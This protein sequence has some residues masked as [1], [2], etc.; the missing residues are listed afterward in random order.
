MLRIFWH[1]TKFSC[2]PIELRPKTWEIVCQLT[3]LSLFWD[4][5][6]FS[7]ENSNYSVTSELYPSLVS[8]TTEFHNQHLSSSFL[9]ALSLKKM[10]GFL[11]FDCKSAANTNF[12]R[13]FL[14]FLHGHF[15]VEKTL[16]FSKMSA[17]FQFF[18][19]LFVVP[20]S[21]WYQ[22][23]VKVA[24]TCFQKC[25]NAAR[26]TRHAKFWREVLSQCG[27]PGPQPSSSK[28][29]WKP[30]FSSFERAINRLSDLK[31]C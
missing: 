1:F 23:W 29:I 11:F 13:N 18:Q 9:R 8:K 26:D 5:A 10:P 31:A 25:W 20:L 24:K 2:L 28:W 4:I 22:R 12:S 7:Y 27:E 16:L 17:D 30:W 15:S 19:F 6:F 14:S 21:H 3:K